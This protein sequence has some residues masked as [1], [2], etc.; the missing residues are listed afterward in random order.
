M[1]QGLRGNKITPLSFN[2]NDNKM[3]KS[4]VVSHRRGG[5]AEASSLLIIAVIIFV[6]VLSGPSTVVKE[7]DELSNNKALDTAGIILIRGPSKRS[8]T[9][10]KLSLYFQSRGRPVHYLTLKG[11]TCKTDLKQKL[12]RKPD[13]AV[14]V[15]EQI[16]ELLASGL[17]EVTEVI[18]LLEELLSQNKIFTLDLSPQADSEGCL[19]GDFPSLSDKQSTLSMKT[20][21]LKAWKVGQLIQALSITEDSACVG[22]EQQVLRGYRTYIWPSPF[23]DENVLLNSAKTGNAKSNNLFIIC[24]HFFRHRKRKTSKCNV[25]W[26]YKLRQNISSESLEYDL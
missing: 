9:V 25:N 1:R 10:M 26:F 16:D 11:L 3:R 5:Y 24:S 15:I 22:E 18:Q 12:A 13:E 2:N 19:N 6:L 20:M 17:P 23:S 4:V 8:L 14:L 7:R 21:C